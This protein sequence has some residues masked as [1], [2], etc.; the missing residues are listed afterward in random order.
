[1]ADDEEILVINARRCT[2][3]AGIASSGSKLSRDQTI[4][5]RR[6]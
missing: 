2:A 4:T 5:F 6:L 3:V 1:M